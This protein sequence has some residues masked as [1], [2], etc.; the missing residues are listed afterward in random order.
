[1]SAIPSISNLHLR[2]RLWI[3]EMNFDINVLR[4]FSDHLQELVLQRKRPDLKDLIGS[5][6]KKFG[7]L[8]NEIDELKNEMHLTKMQ[9]AS[10]SREQVHAGYE[11]IAAETHDQ[12]ARRYRAFRKNFE[13]IK[14]EVD[15]F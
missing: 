11:T 12:L 1:M 6:E 7:E 14:Q 4:I 10:F 9:L 3:A 8:R 2:Y 5:F 13:A 15:R